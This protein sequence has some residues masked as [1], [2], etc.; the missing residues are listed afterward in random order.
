MKTECCKLPSSDSGNRN[1]ALR[2][3]PSA[4]YNAA[5]ITLSRTF[6]PRSHLDSGD[7]DRS[8]GALEESLRVFSTFNIL[9]EG[10]NPRLFFSCDVADDQ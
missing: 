4:T 6:N 10:N 8:H 2:H 3:H 5:S 1:T 7:L 9:I